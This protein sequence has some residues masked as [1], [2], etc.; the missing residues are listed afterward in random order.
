MDRHPWHPQ[1]VMGGGFSG[2]G[3]KF[4]PALGQVLRELSLGESSSFDLSLFGLQ[5]LLSQ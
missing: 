5:R 4:G 2:H 1:V 3:F